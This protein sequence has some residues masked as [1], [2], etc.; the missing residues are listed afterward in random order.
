MFGKLEN[1]TNRQT[2]QSSQHP[3]EPQTEHVVGGWQHVRFDRLQSRTSS[4]DGRHST[5][6]PAASRI[7]QYFEPPKKTHAEQRVG[8]SRRIFSVNF[9]RDFR[10]DGVWIL[11]TSCWKGIIIAI[12][13][14]PQQRESAAKGKFVKK[15]W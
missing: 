15:T 5:T 14:Q 1:A 8:V 9:E 11:E 2:I 4:D 12:K 7:L 10:A 3:N 13:R 6:T